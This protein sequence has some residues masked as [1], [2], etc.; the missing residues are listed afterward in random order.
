M[1]KRKSMP[2][3]ELG[4][5]V[6][7]SYKN[8]LWRIMNANNEY[9]C[10]D[11]LMAL[12]A[13]LGYTGED[14]ISVNKVLED[15]YYAVKLEMLINNR[16]YLFN[17]HRRYR[18]TSNG[19]AITDD[20]KNFYKYAY[21]FKRKEYTDDYDIE[22]ECKG[23][24]EH[25]GD[26][27]IIVEKESDCIGIYVVRRPFG[28]DR[29]LAVKISG[30]NAGDK[31]L[32]SI[33]NEKAVVDYLAGVKQSCDIENI[34]TDVLALALDGDAKNCSSI[35]IERVGDMATPD[36]ISRVWTDV[37]CV[38]DGRV[39]KFGKTSR[40]VADCSV[41]NQGTIVELIGKGLMNYG[42]FISNDIVEMSNFV[43]L[44]EDLPQIDPKAVSAVVQR[45]KE[46]FPDDDY[47]IL[48]EDYVQSEKVESPK[49]Y[50]K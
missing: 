44:N 27:T 29:T 42:V 33:N 12:L 39:T 25:K 45:M 26:A 1:E 8:N 23:Y 6:D 22:I 34:Y 7:G 19:V 9:E 32:F 37:V 10:D 48:G 30:N 11:M 38:E 47:R 28:L 35:Q 20:G 16:P 40:E 18:G 2:K 3:I 24:T 4:K 36:G 46:V 15:A 5:D 31:R 43:L 21:R 13:S 49:E 50:I 41:S 17:F 14:E